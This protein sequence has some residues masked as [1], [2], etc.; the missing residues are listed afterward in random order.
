MRPLILTICLLLVG[1]AHRHDF[2]SAAFSFIGVPQKIREEAYQTVDGQMQGMVITV[3]EMKKGKYSRPEIGFD[4][5]VGTEP[6]LEIGAAYFFEAVYDRHGI[7]YTRWEKMKT[8]PNKSLQRTPD[9]RP[10][11]SAESDSR[12]R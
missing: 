10:V 3:V 9:T 8:R 11:S 6:P 12:R 2:P 1:C 4:F 7:R 5:A